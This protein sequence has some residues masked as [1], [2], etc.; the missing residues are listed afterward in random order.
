[1]A[2]LSAGDADTS[3][4]NTDSGFEWDPL[5]NERG[6][7]DTGDGWDDSIGLGGDE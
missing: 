4:E 5:E 7:T 6:G 1:M 2:N 3:F